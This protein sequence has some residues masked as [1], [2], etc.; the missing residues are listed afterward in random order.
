MPAPYKKS[1]KQRKY[2]EDNVKSRISGF[3]NKQKYVNEKKTR[4]GECQCGCGKK[5][6]PENV[7]AFDFAHRPN[8]E[9]GA[10]AKLSDVSVLASNTMSPGTAIPLIDAEFDKSVLK[11]ANCHKL[12]DTDVYR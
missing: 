3:Y 7:V 1:K 6:T 5:V 11:Y 8:D 2:R 12:Q 4:I 9:T 10:G